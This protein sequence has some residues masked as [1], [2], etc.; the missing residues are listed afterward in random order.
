MKVLLTGGAGDLGQYLCR[1]LVGMGHKPV[2]FDIKEPA[3][4]EAKNEESSI[5]FVKGSVLEREELK[6]ALNDIDIIVHIAAW[7]GIHEVKN[8][9][10]AWE[11]FDLNVTGTFNLFQ[12]AQ[13][14]GIKDIVFISSTSI[15]ERFGV[16]G[17]TKVLGEEIATTYANRHNMNVIT[18][19]PRAFIPSYNREVYSNYLEWAKWFWKGAVHISDVS[20]AVI[21]SVELLNDG[22]YDFNSGPLCL[23]VDGAYEYTEEDL[24]NWDNEGSGSTFKKYYAKF[25]EMAESF[26]LDPAQ[27]PKVLDISETRSV[28]NYRPL[29]S[30][31]TLL[32]ELK[33]FGADGPYGN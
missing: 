24:A 30:A 15:D 29:Y 12:S 31:K 3:Q 11:F 27:K 8:Q 19:R 20:Q 13:E 25:Y 6:K 4:E 14:A 18:L 1:S 21:K 28:L 10:T 9:K 33:R 16:Y 23:T 2:V 7:H 5:E 32:M 26:G 17:H 22:D